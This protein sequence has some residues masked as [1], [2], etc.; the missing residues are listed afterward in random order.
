MAAVPALEGEGLAALSGWGVNPVF[1]TPGGH[2]FVFYGWRAANGSPGFVDRE[3]GSVLPPPARGRKAHLPAP[4]GLRRQALL[5][6]C[7]P[8]PTPGL[9][10]SSA[11]REQV[12]GGGPEN[13][14]TLIVIPGRKSA[15]TWG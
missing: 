2:A 11:S 6:G 5:C 15:V 13:I 3:P 12:W 1:M 8:P 9:T 7:C 4:Q 14:H 10:F